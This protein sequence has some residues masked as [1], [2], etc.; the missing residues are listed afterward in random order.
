VLERA[1][2]PSSLAVPLSLAAELLKGHID[3]VVGNGVRWGTRSTL[4]A[5]LSPFLELWAELELLGFGHSADLSEDQVDALCT[6]VR[7]ASDLLV[8]H[9]SPSVA[10]SPPDGAVE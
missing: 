3:T 10:R 2:E 9:V 4:A 8:L 7:P 5:T 6:W 1:D